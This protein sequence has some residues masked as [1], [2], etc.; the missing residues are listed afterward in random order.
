MSLKRTDKT[1]TGNGTASAEPGKDTPQLRD[2]PEVNAR[3][4]DYIKANPKEWAYIQGLRRDRLERSL[5]LQ[6]V[7]KT[8]RRERV[9]TAVLKKLDENPELKEAYRTLVKNLPAEQ[10]EKAMASIAMQTQRT[11]APKQQQAAGV[12]V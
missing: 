12:K 2:N 9:R 7:N 4:D 8:E 6:Y 5:V 10:Q 11:I 1:T 3:I